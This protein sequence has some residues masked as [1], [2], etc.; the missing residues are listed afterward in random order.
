MTDNAATSE[1]RGILDGV[2]VLDFTRI[3]AGP[4]AAMLLGD[5][6]ADVTKVESLAGDLARDWGRARFG[7]NRDISALFVSTNRNK[8][9][10]AMNL[11][12]PKSR[13]IINRLIEQS[14]VVI[15]S[16]RNETAE[17]M[18]IGYDDVK[19]LN[20]AA[21]YCAVT[22]FGLK[23]P[24]RNAPG[25]DHLMQC[26]AGLLSITGEKDRPAVRIG[27]S[28]V[29]MLTGTQAALGI[30][31]ALFNRSLNGGGG[32]FVDSSIYDSALGFMSMWIAEYSGTGVVPEKMGAYHPAYPP[33]GNFIA[34]DGREFHLA[35]IGDKKFRV[36]C[37][38]MVGLPELADDPR[39]VT[40]SDRAQH[41]DELYELLTPKFL[42]KTA[43]EWVELGKA[44]SMTAT[45][46]HTVD[47]VVEQEQAKALEAIIGYE[48]IEDAKTAGLPI[49]LSA[50]PASVRI[51]PPML[52]EHTQ[53]IL[54]D[55]GY[56]QE[57]IEALLHDGTVVSAE[58]SMLVT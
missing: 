47:E 8:R 6:G 28:T 15:H 1:R 9:G 21:I 39:F 24:L 42:E 23:G 41:Q 35:A 50:S 49:R 32:Q 40:T 5:F 38:E 29:D 27:P 55:L 44:H 52:G 57:E 53:A 37:E 17:A 20:P 54:E 36:L 45:L 25:Q 58:R 30:V 56:S 12:D 31:L 2:R 13:E 19:S 18:G 11:R 7:P 33:C 46:I 48:G 22:G 26:Y 14:D 16:Y 10:L 34:G 51:D 4:W 43:A 3:M